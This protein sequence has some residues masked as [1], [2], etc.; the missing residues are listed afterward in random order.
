[1]QTSIDTLKKHD[2]TKEPDNLQGNKL[3]AALPYLVDYLNKKHYIKI[4]ANFDFEDKN[5]SQNL[6]SDLYKI[7]Y[8]A[9]TSVILNSD[10]ETFTITLKEKNE[11]LWLTFTDDVSSFSQFTS[12]INF[13]MAMYYIRQIANKYNASVNT[14]EEQN[15]GSQLVISIP[16][17]KLS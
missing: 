15:Q 1:M 13:N 17:M 8:E 3:T 5:L 7:I 12:K 16:L 2:N 9:L 10:G 4:H 11:K 14:F 6:Q